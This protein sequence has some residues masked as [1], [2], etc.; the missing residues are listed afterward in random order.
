MKT[1]EEILR[2][3]WK[4][5]EKDYVC[6][7]CELRHPA[8]AI[9]EYHEALIC[10]QCYSTIEREITDGIAFDQAQNAPRTWDSEDGKYIKAQRV[11][12]LDRDRWTIMPDSPL[13]QE[14]QQQFIAYLK[15]LHR[16]TIDFA[17]PDDLVWPE[18]PELEYE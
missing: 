12:L 8:F 14:C 18:R 9:V 7:S 16:I 10:T 5:P 17:M 4:I 13:T 15:K 1:L 3:Q 11:G 2:D 6:P